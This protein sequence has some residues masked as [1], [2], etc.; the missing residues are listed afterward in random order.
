MLFRI[1]PKIISGC[2][3]IVKIGQQK[4]KI[5][6]NEG[7][8]V[9]RVRGQVVNL[10]EIAN[11]WILY[12][13]VDMQFTIVLL[14][15]STDWAVLGLVHAWPDERPHG[16]KGWDLFDELCRKICWCVSVNYQQISA[17]VATTSVADDCVCILFFF[18]TT[19]VEKLQLLCCEWLLLMFLLPRKIPINVGLV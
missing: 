4:S 16:P 15:S 18:E 6:Q 11:T 14:D 5:L 8:T 17:N 9:L 13:A 7:G 10:V 12:A 19:V 1:C 3:K 2:R